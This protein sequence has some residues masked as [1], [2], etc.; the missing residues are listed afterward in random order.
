MK[1]TLNPAV[2]AAHVSIERSKTLRDITT[3][4]ISRT[5]R[6]MFAGKK[7]VLTGASSGVGEAAAY[8]FADKGAEL[9]LVARSRDALGA[10]R[11]KIIAAG[12]LAHVIVGDVS[13]E[14]D[15]ARLI[16]EILQNHG[17]PD[18]LINNAGRSIRRTV[19]DSTD[20]LHDYQR[21]MAVNYF[22]PVQLTLGLLPGMK[23]AGHGQIINVSTWGIA[24]GSVPKFSAYASSKAALSVFS[25]TIDIELKSSG[26]KSTTVYFS[27]IKTP[28]IAP[29]EHY[30]SIP[31]LS[32]EE[33]ADWLVHAV[34]QRPTEVIPRFAKTLRRIAATSTATVDAIMGRW[35]L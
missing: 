22:G 25:R 23:Q 9:I 20:R 32:A 3:S 21:T 31:T 19:L 7:I 10:V 27:L 11:D 34:A 1:K 8:K 4:A 24:N 5:N 15:T 30:Q 18:V 29:T 16:E 28:M 12:G 26:I 2:L 14:A 33:A 6:E 35:P 13:D 17:T